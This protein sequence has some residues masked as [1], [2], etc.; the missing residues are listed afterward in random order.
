MV[1]IYGKPN[2]RSYV[3]AKKWFQ[4]NEIPIVERNIY[5]APLTVDEIQKILRLTDNG[6]EDIIATRSKAL[7]TKEIDLE[8]L[9]M[10]DLYNLIRNH[11]AILKNPIIHDGKKLMTG[12]NEY[13]IR[14]FLPRTVRHSNYLKLSH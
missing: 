10:N 8:Q 9:P 6:T 2:D 5:N 13:Q 1:I 12:Y 4:E 11:P 3:K 14:R 7:Q